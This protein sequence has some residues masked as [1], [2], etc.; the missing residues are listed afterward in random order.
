M[1]KLLLNLYEQV[2]LN[3]QQLAVIH[4]E[5]RVTY[6]Q[7]W[8]AIEHIAERLRTLGLKPGDGVALL[9]ENSPQYIATYYAIW[10]AGGYVVALNTALK[11]KELARLITHCGTQLLLH[12]GTS[13][14]LSKLSKILAK[15]I[16]MQAFQSDFKWDFV[17]QNTAQQ[18]NDN[19]DSLAAIIYTSGTTGHPKGV[20]L[21]H[22]NLLSNTESIINYLA[23]TKRDKVMCVLPFFY[24]YG[25]SVMHTHLAVGA[26]LLLENSF[27]FPQKILQTMERE[28]VTGFSGVPSTFA[29]LLDRTKLESFHFQKLR[30]ITQAGGGMAPAKIRALLERLDS[31]PFFVMYGQTEASARLTYLEPEMLAN[32]MG[33][34][35]RALPGVTLKT[36]DEH[37]DEVAIGE[38]GEVCAKGDNVMLGY[39][40]EPEETAK[41]IVDGWLKT[42]DVGY[43]DSD[44][45]LFL[46]GRNREM[47]KSGAH[48]IAAVE[49]EETLSEYEGVEEIAIVGVA[50]E[51]LGQALKAFIVLDGKSPFEKRGFLRFCKEHLP[52]YK[53]PKSIEC[54]D[55]LPKTASG[56][57]KKH[58]LVN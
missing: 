28:S 54:V 57:V 32:K 16:V 1:K 3:K 56:K 10:H 20:M 45:Y 17:E 14:E 38:Q 22:K 43:L 33:S 23:L 18:T 8:A 30:Y 21:S 9:M 5:R 27:L 19:A 2:L 41:V 25:N 7:L 37:G 11:A 50:D 52:Q 58:L 12:N 13:K 39:L 51:I 55:G 6:A 34:V 29:L 36:V 53:I 26:T 44:G 42:G 40:N 35:G 4:G 49:I 46:V 47:I 31:V 48:R 15:D 24:S